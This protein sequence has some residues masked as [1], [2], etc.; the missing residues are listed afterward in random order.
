MWAQVPSTI[1]NISQCTSWHSCRP[2]TRPRARGFQSLSELDMDLQTSCLTWLSCLGATADE[3][4]LRLTNNFHSLGLT[5]LSLASS[6]PVLL[7]LCLCIATQL[8]SLIVLLPLSCWSEHCQL[9]WR[10][11]PWMMWYRQTNNLSGARKVHRRQW[12]KSTSSFNV[13]FDKREVCTPIFTKV[14][15]QASGTT[16]WKSLWL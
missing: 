6:I 4:D 5:P 16:F 10:V 7:S 8:L 12:S 13:S 15:Y 11:S 9:D 3:P 1:F 14:A 2:T